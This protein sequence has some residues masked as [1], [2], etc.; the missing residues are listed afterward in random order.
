MTA[1]QKEKQADNKHTDKGQFVGFNLKDESYGIDI[2]LIDEIIRIER[3]INIP[4]ASN[5][6]EG[7]IH[8]RNRIIPIISLRK[9]FNISADNNVTDSTRIIIVSSNDKPVGLIVDKVD[10]VHTFGPND[11][12]TN[13][14]QYKKDGK[15]EHYIMGVTKNESRIIILLDVEALLSYSRIELDATIHHAHQIMGSGGGHHS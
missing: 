12:E 15:S 6:I 9:R 4:R 11:V 3:I 5:Y 13:V 7:F 8:L 2:M 10:K 1:S 14:R